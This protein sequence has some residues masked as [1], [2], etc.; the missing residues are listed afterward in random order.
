M[1]AEAA[2]AEEVAPVAEELLPAASERRLPDVPQHSVQD[3][4]ASLGLPATAGLHRPE[5]GEAEVSGQALAQSGGAHA[6]AEASQAE[7]GTAARAEPPGRAM[8][9][10]PPTATD[11]ALLAQAA[12]K[13]AGAGAARDAAAPTKANYGVL[14]ARRWLQKP[15]PQPAPQPEP[16]TSA[17]L[18]QALTE[19]AR[20]ADEAVVASAGRLWPA[21]G[22][23]ELHTP[24]SPQLPQAVP[25]EPEPAGPVHAGAQ[26]PPSPLLATDL[27]VRLAGKHTPAFARPAALAEASPSPGAARQAAMGSHRPAAG[28]PEAASAA[29]PVRAAPKVHRLLRD[30]PQ[31]PVPQPPTPGEATTPASGTAAEAAR[32]AVGTSPRA[33]EAAGRS[34]SAAKA[35][36][37]LSTPLPQPQLPAEG[38]PGPSG[39]SEAALS[40]TSAS[41]A[42]EAGRAA[43]SAPKQHRRL[44][45]PLLQPSP[46]E[47]APAARAAAQAARRAPP[48]P[49][50]AHH[51]LPRVTKP[52]PAVPATS[53]ATRCAPEAVSEAAAAPNAGHAAAAPAV[54]AASAPAEDRGSQPKRSAP[55]PAAALRQALATDVLARFGGNRAPFVPGRLPV[56][57]STPQM[58]A[59]AVGAAPEARQPKVHR[60]LCMASP[61]P[62]EASAALRPPAEAARSAPK[63]ASEAA[64]AP[65]AEVGVA[66]A[67]E[68]RPGATA[69]ARP[70]ASIRKVH[71][72]LSQPVPAA[73]EP[74]PAAP[75]PAPE[76]APLGATARSQVFA[77][78][79]LAGF[80]GR[81][82]S[83]PVSGPAPVPPS[84]PRAAA[85]A[86]RAAAEAA[87][88]KAHRWLRQAPPPPQEADT[89]VGRPADAARAG[90][91][92]ASG[93]AAAPRAGD[94]AAAVARPAASAPKAHRWLSQPVPAAPEREPARPEPLARPKVFATDVLA[95]FAVKQAPA[96]AAPVPSGP[97][98][99]SL[100]APSVAAEPG[101]GA[102]PPAPRV[103]RWLAAPVQPAVP[104]EPAGARGQQR[105]AAGSNPRAAEDWRRAPAAGSDPRADM[106]RRRAWPAAEERG[107]WDRAQEPPA[108]LRAPEQR[109]GEP[110]R[111]AAP[112]KRA[113]GEAMNGAPAQPKKPLRPK[114]KPKEAPKPQPLVLPDNV[115]VRQLAALLSAQ[116]QLICITSTLSCFD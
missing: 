43:A 20:P 101:A 6:L 69:A 56:S 73:L 55:E 38:T 16:A 54:P 94:G 49:E 70:A 41:G 52:E 11:A 44:S 82:A 50:A 57:P 5:G 72:W 95:R 100:S 40:A 51:Q 88:P 102:P 68:A 107:S 104:V 116:P 3:A 9:A 33:T 112:Q 83:S 32:P 21:A 8:E 114:H 19:S 22:A 106:T 25:A 111:E 105:Q 75:A 91:E 85:Q 92:A 12:A 39:A 10:Q 109:A 14:W 18:A 58:A 17:R 67:L 60:W 29:Q 115:T 36:R 76:P 103:H 35:H 26:A 45:A 15:L 30:L 66:V 37:W 78:D 89:M 48:P 64:A 42:A 98:P 74:L 113:L 31:L 93:A 59:E 87:Q 62:L 71:R 81:R 34:T 7:A 84:A 13:G 77:T 80:A 23:A 86:A 2:F 61:P 27:L 4:P 110:H 53:E 96:S 47:P 108:R 46:A 24:L 65:E 90:P 63:A 79:V 99:G 28:E 1:C 97:A